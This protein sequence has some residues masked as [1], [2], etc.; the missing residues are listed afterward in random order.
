MIKEQV[1]FGELSRRL[2]NNWGLIYDDRKKYFELKKKIWTERY[3]QRQITELTFNRIIKNIDSSIQK[4]EK[5]NPHII[6]REEINKID[7]TDEIY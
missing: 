6:P 3:N 7:C 4:I 1:E 2:K 5:Y